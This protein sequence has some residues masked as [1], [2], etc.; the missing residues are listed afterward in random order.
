MERTGCMLMTIEQASSI[1][2]TVNQKKKDELVQCDAKQSKP[3]TARGDTSSAL[4]TQD[5][6]FL[7]TFLSE[8]LKQLAI[9]RLLRSRDSPKNIPPVTYGVKDTDPP[10]Q[11]QDTAHKSN[12]I[13]AEQSLRKCESPLQTDEAEDVKPSLKAQDTVQKSSETAANHHCI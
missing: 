1:T 12:E 10:Q 6:L 13:A 5:T 9:E 8:K 4:K 2:E 7:P 11:V 3:E